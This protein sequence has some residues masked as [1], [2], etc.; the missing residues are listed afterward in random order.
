MQERTAFAAPRRASPPATQ[1][2]NGVNP[3]ETPSASLRHGWWQPA[4]SPLPTPPIRFATRRPRSNCKVWASLRLPRKAARAA[5]ASSASSAKDTS[6]STCSIAREA[7]A[8]RAETPCGRSRQNCWRALRVSIRS[9]SSRSSSTMSGRSCSIPAARPGGWLLPPSRTSSACDGSSSSISAEG[10]TAHEDALRLAIRLQ[11][12]VIFL[13][14]DGDD[15][16]LSPPQLEKIRHLAAGIVINA[17]EFGP[18]PKPPGASFLAQL[19][20]QNGGGYAYVDVSRLA[21]GSP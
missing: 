19:A 17:I 13:L 2:A 15:P 16:K 5:P 10:G 14:T 6:S 7:W 11:P 21:A 8:G 4:C 9:T 12:D 1:L 18:G 3:C 20:R